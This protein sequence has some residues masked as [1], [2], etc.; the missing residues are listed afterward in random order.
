VFKFTQ[1]VLLQNYTDEFNLPDNVVT[2]TPADAGRLLIPWQLIING[3]PEA[4]QS[5]YSIEVGKLN[6][7]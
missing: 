7:T 2:K 6:F 3:I 4:Q 1:P 5:T